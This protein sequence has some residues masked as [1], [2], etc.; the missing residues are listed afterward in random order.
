M[1]Q[2][3][4]E[5]RFKLRI[6]RAT[7]EVPVFELTVANGGPK[8]Q[9]AKEG[10]CRLV[11][12]TTGFVIPT[13]AMSCAMQNARGGIVTVAAQAASLGEFSEL[14]GLHP[15]AAGLG[16]PVV[17]KTGIA[18]HFDFHLEYGRRDVPANP[19]IFTALQQQLGLKLEP[20][21]GPREFLVIDSVQQ[22]SGN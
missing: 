20:A 4:L 3:L 16:R 15:A 1:M 10:S 5:D 19:S 8:L 13:G 21:K 17:D 2:A 6:H 11:S 12:G 7:R 18:G 14:L 22:P 9:P